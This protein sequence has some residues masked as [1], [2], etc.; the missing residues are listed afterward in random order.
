M[1]ETSAAVIPA[2]VKILSSCAFFVMILCLA[3]M[4]CAPAAAFGEVFSVV[5]GVEFFIAIFSIGAGNIY[6]SLAK[7]ALAITYLV[8]MI[9]SIKDFVWAAKSFHVVFSKK[10]AV[11][12]PKRPAAVNGFLCRYAAS[13]V[14][15]ALCFAILAAVLSGDG[16][17]WGTW[18]VMVFG[19]LY[20]LCFAFF[21]AYPHGTV[22]EEGKRRYQR[23]EW[24]RLALTMVSQVMLIACLAC[25]AAFLIV[26]AGDEPA[27][28]VQMLVGGYYSGT[29]GFFVTFFNMV[30]VHIL[31]IVAICFFV[32][33]LSWT[34]K[35]NGLAMGYMRFTDKTVRRTSVRILIVMAV[36][37]VCACVFSSIG[38]YGSVLGG[39]TLSLWWHEIRRHYLP[40]ILTA[41][42]GILI[43]AYMGEKGEPQKK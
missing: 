12:T 11:Q 26:P 22:D 19:A 33:M 18:L 24:N 2:R 35:G 34:L 13:A 3:V 36:A 37:A 1:E 8:M 4:L 42:M 40:V 9:L 5:T 7:L 17:S 21:T 32:Y 30:G 14:F 43:A 39:N 6:I 38:I 10:I 31:E 28:G 29:S 20:A 15:R 23:A 25:M 41:V 27:F 16:A